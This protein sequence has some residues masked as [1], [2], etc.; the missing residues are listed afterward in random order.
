MRY[1]QGLEGLQGN[2]LPYWQ[3]QQGGQNASNQMSNQQSPWVNFAG[4]AVNAAAGAYQNYQTKKNP[5][6]SNQGTSTESAY[7]W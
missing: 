5:T 7:G 1:L 2:D 4:N 3:L 6:Y